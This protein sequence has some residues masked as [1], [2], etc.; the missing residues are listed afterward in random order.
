MK[1]RKSLILLLLPLCLPSCGHSEE[2]SFHSNVEDHVFHTLY[3]DRY[4]LWDNKRCYPEIALPS[5]ASAMTS[6]RSDCDYEDRAGF[7][8]ELWEKEG[9]SSFHVSDS[10]K[11]KPGLDS[12]AYAFAHKRIPSPEG[13]V[14]LIAV[15]IRSGTYEAEWASN[16]TLGTEGD[17]QGMSSSAS[18]VYDG[19]L[20]YLKDQGYSGKTKFWLS[21]YSRGGSVA[22]YLAGTLLDALAEG[23][24]LPTI[25]AGKED[26]YA[27]CF[28]PPACVL[29]ESRDVHGERYAGVKNIMN[30][31]DLMPHIIPAGWGFARFGEDLYYPD[32][33]TDIRFSF[34]VRKNLLSRYRFEESGHKYTP[35][36]VDEWKFYD[37]GEATAKEHNLPRESLFPS[38]GR[39]ARGVAR[40]LSSTFARY[41]YAGLME[42]G[43]RQIIATFMGLNPDVSENLID[44]SNLLNV[45]SSYPFLRNL[46]VELQ[47]GDAG[48]FAYDAG[49]LLY[50]LFG[51]NEQ[52]FDAIQELLDGA[53]FLLVA[54]PAIFGARKDLSL[55][56]FSRDNITKL[57]QAHYTELN[58]SF[59]RSLDRRL[60][61]EGA[62][63]L[64]DGSYYLLHVESPK[65][66]HL[67]EERYGEIF[68]FQGGAMKSD[69]LSAERLNDGS[70]DIYLPK[71]GVYSYRCAA[72][73]IAISDVDASGETHP[74]KENLPLSGRIAS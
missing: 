12:I 56:L 51:A 20:S 64:N 8:L 44:T 43:I 23:T 40:G 34:G 57:L 60:Y 5:Y 49:L 33:L 58:Y 55:Q 7:L 69:V 15:T 47:Q 65:E 70:V 30:F 41:L 66:F 72:T 46:L 62:V 36:T 25:S 6:I 48:N 73:S 39:F 37:V 11:T 14:H 45:I 63:E 68:A 22:N 21:G 61:G 16:I 28:E 1:T 29:S 17:A 26:V 24:F 54:I 13:P 67:S 38:I 18:I 4:F 3:D 42:P 10:F 35:Y 27:Y 9:F 74:L 50:E 52:N 53:F 32:R 71:N 19:L 31:N 59:T 2:I